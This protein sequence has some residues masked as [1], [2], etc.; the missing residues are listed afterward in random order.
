MCCI[1]FSD[2]VQLLIDALD[3]TPIR[4][5]PL[6]RVPFVP[7]NEPLL[8][9]LDTFQEGRSHMAIVSRFSVAKAASVKQAVKRGLTQ[10]LRD[11][12]L[13]DTDSSSSGSESEEEG[14]NGSPQKSTRNRK[15]E[16]SDSDKEASVR[17]GSIHEDRDDRSRRPKKHARFGIK[18]RGRNKKRVADEE[19]AM[20]SEDVDQYQEKQKSE[21]L[22]SSLILPKSSFR[23]YEQ[24]MPAD[25]VLAT[26]GADEVGI[27]ISCECLPP[28]RSSQFLE[29]VDA[30]V[31]PLG[32]I[33]LEDVLEGSL[34]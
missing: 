5:I 13:G 4:K 20:P 9:I 10:R 33:T 27:M 15:S 26:E 31:M 14:P 25:A 11:R 8:G 19:M 2:I 1:I 16:E 18:S 22:K 28:K 21:G 29:G 6:N 24:N 23:N 3:A 12:V 7:N 30:A 17:T 34:D 32:I